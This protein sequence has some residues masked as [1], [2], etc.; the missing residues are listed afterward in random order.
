M[1]ALLL[2]FAGL[3]AAAGV[4]GAVY[5]AIPGGGEEEVLQDLP[6]AIVTESGTQTLQGSATAGRTATATES[7][8]KV[9]DYT[10]PLYGYMFQYPA[11]WLVSI[12][13]QKGGSVTLYSYDPATIPPEQAGMPVPKDKL[14]AAF[15]LRKASS[16]RWS[17]GW[18]REK[19]VPVRLPHH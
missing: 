17:S 6:S 5:V 10:D 2:G 1:K 7:A 14:K 12:E 15:G 9:L 16:S 4:A 18:Q 8:D 19:A 3:V 11:T 13:G